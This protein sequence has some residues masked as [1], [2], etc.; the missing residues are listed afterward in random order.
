MTGCWASFTTTKHRWRSS[1]HMLAAKLDYAGAEIGS[2]ANRRY[3]DVERSHAEVWHDCTNIRKA[4]T[5]KT[6]NISSSSSALGREE[7]T[8]KQ[9]KYRRRRSA[10]FENLQPAE[11]K[12]IQR[13]DDRGARA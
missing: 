1:G 9:I 3:E 8:T 6:Q 13:Q 7:E 2:S 11:T 10:P 12:N 5:E 4:H